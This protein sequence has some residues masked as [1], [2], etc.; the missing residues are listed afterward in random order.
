MAKTQTAKVQVSPP[1]TPGSAG[2]A[3]ASILIGGSQI[4]QDRHQTS[5]SKPRPEAN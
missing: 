4:S 1:G 5:R 3:P 2:T